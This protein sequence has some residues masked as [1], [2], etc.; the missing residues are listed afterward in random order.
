MEGL[1]HPLAPPPMRPRIGNGSWP[2]AQSPPSPDKR[3]TAAEVLEQ[4]GRVLVARLTLESIKTLQ[5]TGGQEPS[6]RKV[7]AR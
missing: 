5:T 7:I 2:A 1:L 3:L 6:T 4:T